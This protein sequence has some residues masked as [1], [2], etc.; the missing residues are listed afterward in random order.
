MFV[1][2]NIEQVDT[3]NEKMESNGY[4]AKG[5]NGVH[6][7]RY[8]VK[9]HPD[10]SGNH[11]HHVHIY[12]KGH[13]DIT[14]QL[15]FRDYLRTDRESFIVYEKIKRKASEKYRNSPLEYTDA[16]TDCVMTIMDKAKAYFSNIN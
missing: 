16:K 14:D 11:T 12:Q 15:M 3:F 8:F 13:Q 7:R 4:S 9:L 5:E 6:N 1:V 10:K 2:D